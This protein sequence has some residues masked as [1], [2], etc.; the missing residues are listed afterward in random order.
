MQKSGTRETQSLFLPA[1]AL[2][3]RWFLSRG[4]QELPDG[5]SKSRSS[6]CE[7]GV[8]GRMA[9]G[10]RCSGG[11]FDGWAD[12]PAQGEETFTIAARAPLLVKDG[13]AIQ[14]QARIFERE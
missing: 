11:R 13:I 6:Q 12:P 3:I 8:A 2:S 1:G 5:V 10:S 14:T 7:G 4:A 9:D